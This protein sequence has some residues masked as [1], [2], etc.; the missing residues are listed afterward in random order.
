MKYL[1]TAVENATKVFV[2]EI[3][4]DINNSVGEIDVVSD[5]TTGEYVV[6]DIRQEEETIKT[7]TET[8]K[9]PFLNLKMNLK[10]FLKTKNIFYTVKKVS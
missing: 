5:L 1:D 8:L 9:I 6:I 2:D 10:N 4:D 7:S 3:V